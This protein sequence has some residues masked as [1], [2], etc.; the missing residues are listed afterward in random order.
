[1]LNRHDRYAELLQFDC[2]IVSL[3]VSYCNVSLA[4]FDSPVQTPKTHMNEIITPTPS[5]P[6][7]VPVSSI[8]ALTADFLK[9]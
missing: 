5:L 4:L 9:K 8:P 6:Q 2:V 1:M 7:P 3:E